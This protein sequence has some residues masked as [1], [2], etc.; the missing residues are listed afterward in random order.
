MKGKFKNKEN[1]E[2]VNKW[3]DKWCKSKNMKL[4]V[5]EYKAETKAEASVLLIEYNIFTWNHI[6]E[7]FIRLKKVEGKKINVPLQS[8][9]QNLNKNHF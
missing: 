7:Q 4:L 2:K 9:I 3:I 1:I 8:V 5:Q 6:K